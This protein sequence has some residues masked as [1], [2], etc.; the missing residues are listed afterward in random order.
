MNSQA[1]GGVKL[2]LAALAGMSFLLHAC[3]GTRTSVDRGGVSGGDS[4]S[5][6]TP[7]A[8][9]ST[10]S[11][12]TRLA[13]LAPIFQN[14]PDRTL[15][16][17][18]WKLPADAERVL[19]STSNGA[20]PPSRGGLIPFAAADPIDAPWCALLPI[21]SNLPRGAWYVSPEITAGGGKRFNEALVS[22]N[23]DVNAEDP[24][25]V[26][27]IE[28]QV[29]D[30]TK[31]FWSPWLALGTVG[32]G[33]LPEGEFVQTFTDATVGVVGKVE[34]DVFTSKHTFD[35]MRYRVRAF[36]TSAVAVR[37]ISIT[38]SDIGQIGGS[39]PLAPAVVGAEIPRLGLPFFSQKTRDEKLSGRLCSPTSVTMVLNHAGAACTVQGVSEL[40]YDKRFDLFGNWPRNVQAAWGMG[41]PGMLVRFDDFAQARAV[42]QAGVP[43]IASIRVEKGELPAAPYASTDGHL[44]VIEG[45]TAAGDLLVLDPAVGDAAQGR[46]VY[47]AKDMAKVWLQGSD[48]TA[49]L[50]SGAVPDS[51]SPPNTQQQGP[52]K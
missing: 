47:P 46:R 49:Y 19:F 22:W 4:V 33:A 51:V 24:A 7:S 45:M 37:S 41:V 26:A 27:L 9:R 50:L 16:V 29:G 35:R 43:I 30:S 2:M 14:R 25:S 42:L 23:I 36:G 44:I 15:I 18:G 17:H 13:S 32:G 31:G 34:V 21:G 20:P 12:A 48:G 28:L 6:T 8:R 52:R 39:R 38:L 11:G 1:H 5:A 10:V 40:V 3:A